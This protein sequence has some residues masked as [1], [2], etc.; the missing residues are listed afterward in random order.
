MSFEKKRIYKTIFFSIFIFFFTLLTSCSHHNQKD[1]IYIPDSD[2]TKFKVN[3]LIQ[4]SI[5]SK[6]IQNQDTTTK[7]ESNKDT[8]F[9]E[10]S[11]S[12]NFQIQSEKNPIFPK[13][14]NFGSL[15]LSSLDFN[16]K[17]EITKL[18]NKIKEENITKKDFLDD[19]QMEKILLEYELSK[20]SKIKYFVLGTPKNQ[21]DKEISIP[22]RF[23]FD[24]GI[25]NSLFILQ[26]TE[27]SVKI[28][29]V[30]FG[31]FFDNK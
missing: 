30:I 10:V 20:H 23:Y 14:D 25:L 15:D 13:L 7:K 27:T 3:N 8:F 21:I 17:N 28:K 24:D 6:E 31:E 4:N 2:T 1:M 19:F 11:L 9:S 29:Q 16:T 12:S 22:I 18:I 26:N 5:W